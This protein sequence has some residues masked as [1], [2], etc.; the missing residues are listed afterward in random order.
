M[1]EEQLYTSEKGYNLYSL[2]ITSSNGTT[3]DVFPQLNELS[4]F[5]DIYNSTISGQLILNDSNDFFANLPLSGFEFLNI[6]LSKPGSSDSFSLDKILRIYKMVGPQVKDESGGVQSYALYFCSEENL[7]SISKRISKSY[8]GKTISDIVKDILSK[9]LMIVGGKY[10]ESNIE[11]TRGRYDIIIP[12]MNP[13]AAVSWLASRTVS[14]SD[15]G[16]GANFVFYENSEGYHFKSLETLFK[17]QTRAK[18]KYGVRNTNSPEED[19]TVEIQ[20]VHKYEFM[21]TFDVLSG[22]NSGMFSSI[23]KTIDL[24]KLK[25]SD[26]TLNYSDF[27]NKT[28]HIENDTQSYSGPGF[29]FHNGYKDRF[30][31]TVD[32]NYYS[33]MRMYPTNKDHNTYS[34]IV[35]KQ[36][37]ITPNLVESWMLQRI[38]QIN[39]L[40]YF[41]LKMVIPGDTNL[42][43]GDIIEFEVPLIQTKAPGDKNI[44]P[45]HSGR[46]LITAIRHVI[47]NLKY[48]MIV[49]A[50][51]DCLSANYPRAS[52]SSA[53]I[54]GLK[55]Q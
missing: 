44:N 31:N 51:R 49:E 20:Q 21:N 24:T 4:I 12:Y 53:L 33:L 9:Q 39:Q 32:N 14:L 48:E 11:T 34:G 27:F 7:V 30:N 1:S 19:S 40:N 35:S 5:E 28:K 46:Y 52:T 26:V 15:R 13:L 16:S 54:N 10:Q 47:N 17:K 6:G 36:P 43:V 37:G 38:S 29:S 8:R 2:V 50:T 23:L 3:I 25:L 42:T 18:Y 41:K 45:Y 55:R 22:I